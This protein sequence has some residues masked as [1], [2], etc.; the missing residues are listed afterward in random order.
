MKHFDEIIS[1]LLKAAPIG[2]CMILLMSEID[3][4]ENY[5]LIEAFP[6]SFA[7]SFSLAPVFLNLK[8]IQWIF[9]KFEWWII[10]ANLFTA[11]IGSLVSHR[12]C[13]ELLIWI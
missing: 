8:V 9:S 4:P 12:T 13:K 3:L 10:S 2:D 1:A 6:I 7:N 11:V 5:V